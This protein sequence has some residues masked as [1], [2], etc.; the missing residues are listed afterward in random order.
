MLVAGMPKDRK[1]KP[2]SGFLKNP[3]LLIFKVA[4]FI[5][6]RQFQLES[7]VKSKDFSSWPAIL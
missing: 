2:V 7:F 5:R 6:L 1:A 3:L 4:R